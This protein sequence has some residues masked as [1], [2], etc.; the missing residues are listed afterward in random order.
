MKPTIW[1]LALL[2]PFL[3][4]CQ[5]ITIK[6]TVINEE[7]APVQGATILL[8]VSNRSTIADAAGRFAIPGTSA[9]DSITVSSHRL[10][11]ITEPNNERGL[12]SITLKR[13]YTLLDETIIMAYGTTTRRYNTGSISKITTAELSSQPVSNPWPPCMAGVPGL[14]VTQNSGVTGSAI[15]IQLRGQ[16]SLD[17]SLSR[18]DPLMIIDGVPFESG[19]LPSNL[20]SSAANNPYTVAGT[21]PGGISP[22]NSINPTTLKAW[23]YSKMQMQ[24]LYTE[25][26]EPTGHPH[27]NQKKQKQ[28]KQNSL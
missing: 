11:T 22:L 23:K 18:N 10:Q 20:L 28:A 19:N 12:I 1:L 17:L 14:L 13:R 4:M 21:A 27:Y 6:G 9:K 5:S 8:K 15:S 7:G 24:Q 26:G 3:S 25:A 16:S 2:C